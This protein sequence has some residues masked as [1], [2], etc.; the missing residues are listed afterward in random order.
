M[1]LYKTLQNIMKGLITIRSVT[2]AC[3]QNWNQE[4]T[5]EMQEF[6]LPL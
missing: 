2:A 5:L 6:P 4:S 1:C 3:R